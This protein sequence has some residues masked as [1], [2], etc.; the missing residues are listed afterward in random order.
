MGFFTKRLSTKTLAQE[1]ESRGCSCDIS[2]GS[3]V[4][5][6]G[7]PFGQFTKKSAM[8]LSAWFSATNLISNSIGILPIYEKQLKENAKSIVESS[9]IAALFYSTRLTK[10]NLMKKIVID[11]IMKGNAFIYIKRNGQGLPVKL[12]YLQPG[13]VSIQYNDLEDKLTYLVSSTKDVKKVVQPEDMLHFLM[14]SND[15]V[16]TKVNA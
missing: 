1:L 2:S 5:S 12:V 13:K 14:Y 6:L 8:G 3:N 10:F 4:Y 11:V 16:N 7:L 9:A 15:G